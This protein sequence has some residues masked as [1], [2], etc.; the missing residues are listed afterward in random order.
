MTPAQLPVLP[1]DVMDCIARATLA[2]EGSTVQARARLSLVCSAWRDSLR[3]VHAPS[4]S[5]F[6]VAVLISG[7][8]LT[9]VHTTAECLLPMLPSMPRGRLPVAALALLHCWASPLMSE[10]N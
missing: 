7:A 9:P 2:A 4:S 5:V 10:Q 6:Q 1:S 3:G 8:P